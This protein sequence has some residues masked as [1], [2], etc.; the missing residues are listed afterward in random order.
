MATRIEM[1]LP[2]HRGPYPYV[3]IQD[4]EDAREFVRILQKNDIAVNLREVPDK[5]VDAD[6]EARE[7]R[8]IADL[9]NRV[10]DFKK[11]YPGTSLDI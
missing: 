11:N 10:K 5:P 1:G 6:K 9:A 3:V 8:R 2:D 7:E 4:R